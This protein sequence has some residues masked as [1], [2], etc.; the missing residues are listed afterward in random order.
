MDKIKQDNIECKK[1][2]NKIKKE[3][4]ELT[5]KLDQINK[6]SKQQFTRQHT[7]IS[8]LEIQIIRDSHKMK[9]LMN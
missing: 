5:K 2:M 7:R 4:I 3:N 1:E 9:N 8:T 6:T